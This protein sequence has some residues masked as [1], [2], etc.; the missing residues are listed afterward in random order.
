MTGTFTET[1]EIRARGVGVEFKCGKCEA[2]KTMDDF[3]RHQIADLGSQLSACDLRDDE[4]VAVI[5]KLV[6]RRQ[7][8]RLAL[9]AVTFVAVL[10]LASDAGWLK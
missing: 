6:A 5:R 9:F 10:A 3:H 7:I 1:D 8:Y 2:A 4:R